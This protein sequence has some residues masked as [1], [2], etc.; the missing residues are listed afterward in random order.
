[1]Q[2]YLKNKQ[3]TNKIDI[4]KSRLI[5]VRMEHSVLFEEQVSL[6]SNDMSK[7]INSIDLILL[8]KIK[9]KL[10]KKC[11]RH[12]YVIPGTL[13]LLSRS[14]G[15]ASSGRFVGDYIYHV[16]VQGNVLNPPDGIVIEGEVIRKNKMGIYLNYM[17]AIRVIVPRDLHIGNDAFDNIE[18]GEK[19]SVE[20][21]KSRF[22]MNDDSILS[23][24][25]FNSKANNVTKDSNAR[26]VTDSDSDDV[27]VD[28][29]AD[30]AESE[31]EEEE[32]ILLEDE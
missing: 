12:G 4:R 23:V 27:D 2:K 11:S 7:Q 18:I 20:I 31:D 10:E 25:V 30:A 3:F 14:L 15:K 19:I 32:D 8:S 13:K 26:I 17:D 29:D 16:Q 6:N 22:Q 1:M 9:A 21:K 24:G 28:L 5:I